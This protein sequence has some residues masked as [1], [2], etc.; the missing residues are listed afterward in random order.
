MVQNDLT[1]RQLDVQTQQEEDVIVESALLNQDLVRSA[2]DQRRPG[3]Q[4][5]VRRAVE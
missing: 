4:R 1:A 5:G 3:Q 2:A